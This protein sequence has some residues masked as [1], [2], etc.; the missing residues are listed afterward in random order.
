M[1]LPKEIVDKI[2]P[3]VIEIL[4]EAFY[5]NPDCNELLINNKL[6]DLFIELFSHY[7]TINEQKDKE[8]ESLS[9][10]KKEAIAV[11]PDYQKIGELIG[12]KLGTSVH[13]KIVPA[14]EQL[15][16]ENEILNDSANGLVKRS[17]QLRVENERLKDGID[18]IKR[19]ADK[20]SADSYLVYKMQILKEIN[21]L[22]E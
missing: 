6:Q 1:T 18:K 21:S 13:D 5:E 8:I 9:Q 12:L 17:E 15:K 10:W 4:D 22:I 11:M 20:I 3:E 2:G 19:N 14:I 7:S 16:A